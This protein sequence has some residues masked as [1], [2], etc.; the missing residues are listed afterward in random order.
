METNAMEPI[1]GDIV[2]CRGLV[3]KEWSDVVGVRFRYVRK[4][5]RKPCHVMQYMGSEVLHY[6]YEAKVV[7]CT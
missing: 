6:D 3:E 1:A 2:V 7:V 4:R 5:Q